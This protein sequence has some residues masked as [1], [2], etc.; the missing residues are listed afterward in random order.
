MSNSSR[1]QDR[2]REPGSSSAQSE[3]LRADQLAFTQLSPDQIAAPSSLND[4]GLVRLVVT[5][6]MRKSGLSRAEIADRMSYFTGTEVSER[7]LSAFAA[8][9]RDDVRFPSQLE[10]A[11]CAAVG[12]NQLLICRA[13]LAGL[14]FVDETGL[15]L[16]ELGREFLKQKRAAENLQAIET[17]L[18]GV[19]L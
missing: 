2:S 13:E 11:F 5:N 12:D 4:T 3:Q 16:M 1:P 10:R 15:Q 18:R 7:M 17:K 8:E 19:Q 14:H 9:S 6:G